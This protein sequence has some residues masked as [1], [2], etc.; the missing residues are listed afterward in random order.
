MKNYAKLSKF[1]IDRPYHD[2]RGLLKNVIIY[3]P[4]KND[5]WLIINKLNPKH[6]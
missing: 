4:F 6:F 3:R 1:F 5:Y 2:K